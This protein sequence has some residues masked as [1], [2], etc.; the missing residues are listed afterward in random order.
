MTG[1]LAGA[2]GGMGEPPALEG[3]CAQPRCRD[4]ALK[5]EDLGSNPSSSLR[6][7]G[8]SSMPELS[9]LLCKAG[10]LGL[11][12]GDRLR[13]SGEFSPWPRL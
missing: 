7:S 1:G 6:P 11:W 13:L 10:H 8:R 3:P 2:V 12:K 5:P 9:R 4:G